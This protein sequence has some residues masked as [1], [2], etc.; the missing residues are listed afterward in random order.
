MLYEIGSARTAAHVTYSVIRSFD[1]KCLKRE[2]SFL[3]AE[4]I[5]KRNKTPA[6]LLR[7]YDYGQELA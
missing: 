2:Q 1:S 4:E 6:V 7:F 3:L 5:I